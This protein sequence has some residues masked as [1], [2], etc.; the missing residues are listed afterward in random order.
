MRW[1]QRRRSCCRGPGRVSRWGTSS[2]DLPGAAARLLAARGCTVVEV[3]GC[4][5]EDNRL[6]SY[7]R[8]GAAAGR[9][10]CVVWL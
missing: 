6:H 8:D 1:P 5:Y 2:L 7:R 9:Q 3:L 4:T 10:A